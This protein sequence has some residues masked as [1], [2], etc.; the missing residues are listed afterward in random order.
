MATLTRSGNF[1][2]TNI[3]AS[4]EVTS[5]IKAFEKSEAEAEAE[6]KQQKQ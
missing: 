5:L 6:K 1:T 3:L 4:E 2:R